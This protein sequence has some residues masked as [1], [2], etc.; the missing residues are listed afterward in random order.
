MLNI[1]L[2]EDIEI[3]LIDA[4]ERY[5]LDR[6]GLLQYM[7]GFFCGY[8]EL[9]VSDFEQIFEHLTTILDLH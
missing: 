4:V 1:K 3:Q 5:H 8:P 7:F 9:S 2:Q 6:N